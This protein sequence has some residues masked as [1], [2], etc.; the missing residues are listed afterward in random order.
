MTQP[1]NTKTTTTK[2]G[3]VKKGGIPAAVMA[4]IAATVALE[5]GYVANPNDPGGETNRGITKV[6]ARQEGYTGPMRT[7][8]KEVAYNIYY[9]KYFVAPGY[10]PLI[11]IAAPVTEELFDT[12][13]NMGPNRPGS[14]FQQSI[15]ELC[16]TKLAV[17]GKVGNG[18][19]KA[20]ASCQVTYGPAKL[21]VAMLDKLD[22][23]QLAEYGRLVRVN[24]KLKVFYKGWVN[25]RINNVNRKE[26]G[27]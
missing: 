14:W 3:L 4:V 27:K 10:E 21:C 9:D 15:N 25:N 18:T 22:A 11:A 19:V 2:S 16:G 12:T 24:P 1:T 17:D 5:G 13:V 26:C 6:V 23:K 20:Y 7:L 8:P